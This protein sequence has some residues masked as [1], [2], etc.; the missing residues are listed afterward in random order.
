MAHR[1]AYELTNGP[2]PDGLELDHLCR[3]RHCVNPSHIEAVTHREN[4]LRGTGPIPHRARQ[5]HCKHGHEFTPENT[6]RLPNGCRHC[7][8]CS[9]E[10][11]RRRR[12]RDKRDELDRRARE[13]ATRYHPREAA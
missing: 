1:V 8:T 5:S 4:T 6:Y 10:W 3:V 9:I 12:E 7:R 2:I 11:T 13:A